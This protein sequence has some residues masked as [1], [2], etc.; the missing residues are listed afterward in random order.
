MAARAAM[1][2]DCYKNESVSM[3]IKLGIGVNM[4]RKVTVPGRPSFG[5]YCS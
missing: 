1:E 4:C 5:P 2:V 3:M